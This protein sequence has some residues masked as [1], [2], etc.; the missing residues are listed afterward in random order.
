M[1]PQNA[2]FVPWEKGRWRLRCIGIFHETHDVKTFHFECADDD[3]D[4]KTLFLHKPGQFITLQLQSGARPISRSYT[5]ASPPSRPMTLALTIKRDPG[6]LVSRF[7]HDHLSVGDV[8][9][10][11]GPA[12]TFNSAD[13]APR[14]KL[15]MLSGGSGITPVMSMLRSIYDTA[16]GAPD[17]IFLHSARTPADIIFRNELVWMEAERPNIAVFHICEERAERGMPAGLL[18]AQILENHA[19]DFLERTILTC[20][21]KPYMNA[22]NAI[23]KDANFDFGHYYEE[24]FGDSSLRANPPGAAPENIKSA[25]H[26]APCSEIREERSPDADA[27]ES[28][29]KSSNAVTFVKSDQRIY[30]R[31]GESIL[32][33]ATRAGIAISTNCQMGLCGTCKMRLL[34]GEVSMDEDE[35]LADEDRGRGFILTCCG[36]PKGLVAIDL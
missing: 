15:L 7:M 3:I 21:P 33:I 26:P 16:G 35:G 9:S 2:V 5:I 11:V 8:V 36:R 28:T 32:E 20:G 13:I 22:V 19:P 23:L 34:S 17:V 30:Y 29:V 12:G 4:E 25:A 24:S 1:L 27:L 31:H 14:S 6:G 10:A 18:D